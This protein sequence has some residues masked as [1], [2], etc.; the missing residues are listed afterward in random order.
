MRTA[1]T[2]RLLQQDVNFDTFSCT[3]SATAAAASAVAPCIPHER[4]SH[5]LTSSTL[6]M[7]AA[8]AIW[9]ATYVANSAFWVLSITEPGTA[10]ETVHWRPVGG[11]TPLLQR[12]ANVLARL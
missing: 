2:A 11:A 4:A 3:Q 8:R 12:K 5:R 10:I 6:K 1:S 7:A 9:P